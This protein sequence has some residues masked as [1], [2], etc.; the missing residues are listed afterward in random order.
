MRLEQRDQPE[1]RGQ[2]EPQVQLELQEV[3][4]SLGLRVLKVQPELQAVREQLEQ[5]V[6]LRTSSRQE[7]LF[8]LQPAQTSAAFHSLRQSTWSPVSTAICSMRQIKAAGTKFNR[9]KARR[10]RH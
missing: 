8:S 7:V 1:Q 10:L 6:S 2:Q 9:F 4:E 3:Q 5:Q